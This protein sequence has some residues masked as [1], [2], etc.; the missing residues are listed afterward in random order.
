M[1]PPGAIPQLNTL[2]RKDDSYEVV[3]FTATQIPDIDGRKYPAELAG[4]LYPQGIPILDEGQLEDI[5]EKEGIQL[6]VMSYSDLP[7]STVMALASRVNAAGSDFTMIGAQRT[8]LKSTKPVLPSPPCAPAAVKPDNPP[9][10]RRAHRR[11]EKV[12]AIRH[13]MPTATL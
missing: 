2:Y 4:E 10:D 13:P 7:D 11:R 12:V 1:A 5:I 3:A 6:C 8:M 9:G